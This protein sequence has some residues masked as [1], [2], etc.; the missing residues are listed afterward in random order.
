MAQLLY[1][2]TNKKPIMM[3]WWISGILFLIWF[4]AY[5]VLDADNEVHFV[6]LAAVLVMVRKIMLEY[7]K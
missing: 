7:Q 6:F 2:R 3:H 1:L 4:F 5:I